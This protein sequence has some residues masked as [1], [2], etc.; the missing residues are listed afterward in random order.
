[1][2]FSASTQQKVSYNRML[3][4]CLCIPLALNPPLTSRVS[5][6]KP[7]YKSYKTTKLPPSFYPCLLIG[8]E[9]GLDGLDEGLDGPGGV[10]CFYIV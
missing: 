1:M 10:Q 4:F 8:R 7:T 9:E 6:N 5:S 3:N 2:N